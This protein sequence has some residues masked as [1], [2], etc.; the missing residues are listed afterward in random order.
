MPIRWPWAEEAGIACHDRRDPAVMRVERRREVLRHL[1]GQLER[2]LRGPDP[3]GDAVASEKAAQPEAQPIQNCRQLHDLV[4]LG[5]Q[6]DQ[7]PGLAVAALQLAVLLEELALASHHRLR[8]C[9]ETGERG[10]SELVRDR[11]C[12]L[13]QALG[14]Q[15]ADDLQRGPLGS[16]PA[17]G[18]AIAGQPGR[19]QSQNCA[20]KDGSGE[21]RL[22]ERHIGSNG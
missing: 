17:R 3:D 19:Q 15:L 22:E 5:H 6:V 14:R 8:Q 2:S 1:D 21:E 20:G 18:H 9:P 4:E 11:R 12:L 7:R 16:R 13:L 10:P